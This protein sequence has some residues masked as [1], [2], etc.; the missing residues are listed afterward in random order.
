MGLVVGRD[1]LRVHPR[2]VDFI[3]NW[4]RPFKL[5]E[6]RSFM[7]LVQFFRRFVYNLSAR[8]AHLYG[9]LQQRAGLLNLDD[10]AQD[11][12]EHLKSALITA[13][14]LVPPELSEPFRVHFDA[15]QIAVWAA[16]RNMDCNGRDR[17][18]AYTSKKLMAA[19]QNYTVNERELL[20]VI[21]VL[22]RFRC[23]LE[24]S[25]FYVLTDNQILKDLLNKKSLNRLGARWV[26]TI[27]SFNI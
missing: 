16:L 20:A 23:Y 27:A 15:S 11:A 6:A 5:T 9:F 21:L 8:T 17:A 7:G 2:K 3:W 13:P 4:A 12:F 19:E 18:I 25:M 26:D 14:V 10:C 24:G 1:G 22:Q